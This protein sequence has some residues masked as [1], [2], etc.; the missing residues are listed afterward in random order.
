M[1][2]LFELYLKKSNGG[3]IRLQH[4]ENTKHENTGGQQEPKLNS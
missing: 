2:I 3:R 4:K 1:E